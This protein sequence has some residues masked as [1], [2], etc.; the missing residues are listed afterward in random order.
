MNRMAIL[1]FSHKSLPE[2]LNGLDHHLAGV[3]ACRSQILL[4]QKRP[5]PRREALEEIPKLVVS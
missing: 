2:F 1:Q 5:S 3:R 4:T